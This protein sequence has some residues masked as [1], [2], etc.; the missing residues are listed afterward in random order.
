MPS[1]DAGEVPRRSTSSLDALDWDS[2][3]FV[4]SLRSVS[5]PLL[6]SVAQIHRA[7]VPKM[8]AAHGRGGPAGGWPESVA[9]ASEP[10]VW[11][12]SRIGAFDM[13][14]GR[15]ALIGVCFGSMLL[16][17]GR[18]SSYSRDHTTRTGRSVLVG[19]ITRTSNMRLERSRGVSVFGEPRRGSMIWINQFCFTSAQSR[20][21]QPNR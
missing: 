9:R 11:P 5:Q 6:V 2:R 7:A 10:F 3:N 18:R 13:S 17:T 4:S 20:V 12:A 21:A 8:S 14:V 19:G 1:F 15:Y 16:D